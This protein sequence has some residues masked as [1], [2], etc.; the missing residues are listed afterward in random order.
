MFHIWWDCDKIQPF[1]KEVHNLITHITTYSLD[2]TPAQ[3]LLHY[4]SLGK[5]TY[6][7]SLAMH[8]VNAAKLCIPNH[9]RSKIAPSI[10]E[11]LMRISHIKHM[12][13][14]I[15][16]SQ[17]RVH[18]F[19]FTWACWNHFTSSDQ[20]RQYVPQERPYKD[21]IFSLIGYLVAIGEV[22]GRGHTG[23][24]YHHPVTLPIPFPPTSSP[25]EGDIS[26]TFPLL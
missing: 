23:M 14:L 24:T 17:D 2:Y 7:K 25:V 6:Y 1:W 21:Y 18:K 8:M 9:W 5:K 4:T 3:F 26:P 11:W 22:G 20:Y 10:K 16:T 13:E 19:A 12:E 15:Y